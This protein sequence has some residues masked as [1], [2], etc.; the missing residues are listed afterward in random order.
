ME[1]NIFPD[2]DII[3]NVRRY[4]PDTVVPNQLLWEVH[5]SAPPTL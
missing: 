1:G 5:E 2:K 4:M 3:P